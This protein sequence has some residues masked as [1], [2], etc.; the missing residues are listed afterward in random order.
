MIGLPSI[1]KRHL[2][3]FPVDFMRVQDSVVLDVFL[4]QF[5]SPAGSLWT[6]FSLNTIFVLYQDIFKLVTR[7]LSSLVIRDLY[8]P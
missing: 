5:H 8:Y 2:F 6:Q 7:E 3:M 1:G 4:L